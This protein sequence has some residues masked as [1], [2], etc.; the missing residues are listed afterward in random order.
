MFIRGTPTNAQV[1]LKDRGC[2]PMGCGHYGAPRGEGL[3]RGVDLVAGPQWLIHSHVAGKVTKLG[4]PYAKDLSF[5]YV[6]V[7]DSDKYKHRFMYVA[8]MCNVGDSVLVGDIIGSCQDIAGKWGGGMKNHIHYEVK[9]GS[10]Y[11]DP[12][13]WL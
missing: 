1:V 11:Y 3:H 9:K 6:E 5:R 7:T 8:P 2:D 10:E 12:E 13:K 4:Y